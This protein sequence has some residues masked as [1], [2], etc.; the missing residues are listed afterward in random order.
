[1]QIA[2]IA[3]GSGVALRVDDA[4]A[5]IPLCPLVHQLHVSNSDKLPSMVINGVEY[6]TIDE[7]HTLFVK[8]EVDADGLDEEYLR[9]IWI[10]EMPEPERPPEFWCRMF[11][12]NLGILR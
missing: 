3:S 11:T 6:P 9:Q 12:R 1:M 2:H 4:R 10:G 8:R 5:V 7:R